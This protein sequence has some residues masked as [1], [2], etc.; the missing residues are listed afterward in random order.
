MNVARRIREWLAI[1]TRAQY[2]RQEFIPR[3]GPVRPTRPLPWKYSMP[4]LVRINLALLSL[5]GVLVFGML[6]IVLVYLFCLF[7]WA[8]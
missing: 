3:D 8:V 5:A 1:H 4:L 6:A 7:A 2:P